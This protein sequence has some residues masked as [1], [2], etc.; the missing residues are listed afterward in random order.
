MAG[1]PSPSGRLG[2]RGRGRGAPP[3]PCPPG[4]NP[5]GPN[6][7][8]PS[9]PGRRGPRGSLGSNPSPSPG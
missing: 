2:P 7:P 5:P 9:P 8:G 3:G 6:P 1:S 4:P